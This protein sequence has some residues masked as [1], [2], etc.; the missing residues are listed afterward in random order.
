VGPRVAGGHPAN[1]VTARRQVP[2]HVGS[3]VSRMRVSRS[4]S[5]RRRPPDRD[6]V[7][8]TCKPV[9]VSR[10]LRAGAA[11]P[12]AR[13]RVV[14]VTLPGTNSHPR[15]TR[16]PGIDSAVQPDASPEALQASTTLVNSQ[17]HCP[18]AEREARPGRSAPGLSH[19]PA[20]NGGRLRVRQ[21]SPR[22]GPSARTGRR[23]VNSSVPPRR[24]SVLYQLMT[25][26]PGCTS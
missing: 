22:V 18:E 11:W 21:L 8:V 12:R 25:S 26:G 6:Y 16:Q 15:R 1:L 24:R 14:M 23:S 4:S 7:A 13:L 17:S 3:P 10:R 19:M 2:H 5:T 9:G 20:G